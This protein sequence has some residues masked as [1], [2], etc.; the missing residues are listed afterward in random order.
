VLVGEAFWRRG[1]DV[2]F[3]VEEGGMDFEDGDLF[4]FVETAEEI[5]SD[6]SSWREAA[7]V[8]GAGTPLIVR[9]GALNCW[10]PRRTRRRL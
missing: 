7:C 2:E 8:K 6:I 4:R 9:T 1:F 10:A 5:W 3:L